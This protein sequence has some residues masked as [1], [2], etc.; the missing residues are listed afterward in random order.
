M[1]RV[2]LTFIRVMAA[3]W[4]TLALGKDTLL[5]VQLPLY[6]H[7]F[8]SPKPDLHMYN[9]NKITVAAAGGNSYI[10]SEAPALPFVVQ[11]LKSSFTNDWIKVVRPS[12]HS[13]VQYPL[14][15]RS[16]VPISSILSF[17]LFVP[18]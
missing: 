16:L 12:C 7:A 18:S 2:D 13:A 6:P 3:N 5:Q 15:L 11:L 1:L 4:L 8:H 10:M 9:N 14:L 17:S